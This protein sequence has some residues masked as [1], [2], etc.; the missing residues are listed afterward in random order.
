M[1]GSRTASLVV[2]ALFISGCSW[3]GGDDDKELE[4]A[5]LVDIET[6]VDVRKLWSAK[7]GDDAEF[8]R[9]NLRPAGDGN[10]IYAASRDGN[11]VAL[12]AESGKQAWKT[13]LET[14]L[15]AGPGVGDGMVAVGSADGFVIVLNSNDG[16]ERWRVNCE[17]RSPCAAVGRRRCGRSLQQSTTGY[18]PCAVLTARKTGFW[19]N[20][21][22]H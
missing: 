17:W 7:L 6:K 1:R 9:V 8:L 11:V 5:E 10:R 3:F 22:R 19:R 14:D 4:P 18:V 12:D 16:T 15:S 20:R 21:R 2:A 13:E